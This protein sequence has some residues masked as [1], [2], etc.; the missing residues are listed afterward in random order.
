M[1]WDGNERTP[2]TNNS[3][4]RGGG[5]QQ[6]NNQ[7][8]GYERGNQGENRDNRRQ[9]DNRQRGPIGSMKENPNTVLQEELKEDFDYGQRTLQKEQKDE[10]AA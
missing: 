9:N 1:K 10:D 3:R 4:G 2:T 6:R 8:G 5:Q 7:R